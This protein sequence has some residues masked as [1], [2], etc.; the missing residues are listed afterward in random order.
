MRITCPLAVRIMHFRAIQNYHRMATWI[1]G[2]V[3]LVSAGRI[4]LE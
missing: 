4:S 2:L 3:G 1:H